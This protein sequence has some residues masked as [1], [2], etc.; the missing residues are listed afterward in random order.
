MP[1][2]GPRT[3]GG[4]AAAGLAGVAVEAGAVLVLDR[5][6]AVAAADASGIAIE[7]LAKVPLP[8]LEAGLPSV[9]ANG[10]PAL[11]TLGRLTPDA[12]AGSD[13]EKGLAAVACLAPFRV[14]EAVVV[15][16]A[17]ILAIAGGEPALD[18]L[19]RTRALRQWG[20]GAR[21]RVGV[22]AVRAVPSAWTESGIDALLEQAAAAGLAG[23]VVT[24]L[25]QA[26]ADFASAGATA[27]RHELF[28][29]L[30]EEQP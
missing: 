7:G 29:T 1:T 13:I 3:V 11:R 12:Q 16:R 22:L 5:T 21:R 18:V 2:I 17:Y 23:A 30:R 19:T 8:R 27:D 20:V 15:A 4:V 26:L 24:G 25:P 28:L 6:E 14:G 10:G 9:G